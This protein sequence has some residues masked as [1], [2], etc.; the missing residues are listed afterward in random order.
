MLPFDGPAFVVWGGDTPELNH[1]HAHPVQRY[2]FDF[3]GVSSAVGGLRYA[4]GGTQNEDF[5]SLAALSSARWMAWSS[6]Q[7]M[8][9][10]TIGRGSERSH[11]IRQF[12]ADKAQ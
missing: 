7:W 1:H 6:R 8:G 9:C 10:E 5:L 2:A 4:H 11:V 3:A 12:R